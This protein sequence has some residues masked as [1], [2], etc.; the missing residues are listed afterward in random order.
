MVSINCI[1]YNFKKK[2]F[3]GQVVVDYGSFSEVVYSHDSSIKSVAIAWAESFKKSFV[4]R[5]RSL[6]CSD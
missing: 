3:V 5:N 2:L 6:V 4:K 1:E